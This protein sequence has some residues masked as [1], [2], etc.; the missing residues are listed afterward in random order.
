MKD[1]YFRL[2]NYEAHDSVINA[3]QKRFEKPYYQTYLTLQK[4]AKDRKSKK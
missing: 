1:I 3:I 2:V 4:T